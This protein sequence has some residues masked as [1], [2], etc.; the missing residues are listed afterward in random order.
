[1]DNGGETRKHK[2]DGRSQGIIFSRDVEVKYLNQKGK[3]RLLPLTEPLLVFLTESGVLLSLV[4]GLEMEADNFFLMGA[5]AVLALIF[6]LAYKRERLRHLWLGACVAFQALFGLLF[7]YEIK[8]GAVYCI[9]RFIRYVNFYYETNILEYRLDEKVLGSSASYETMF[10]LFIAMIFTFIITFI[11]CGKGGKILY[12]GTTTLFIALPFAV[13]QVPEPVYLMLY[14]GAALAVLGGGFRLQP[15]IRSRVRLFILLCTGILCIFIW[16]IFPQEEYKKKIDADKIKKEIQQVMT[17]VMESKAVSSFLNGNSLFLD[18]RAVGGLSSGSL[19]HVGQ[20]V[21]NNKTALKIGLS[22]KLNRKFYVRGYVG[23]QIN[24][25]QWEAMGR[26]DRDA[27]EELENIWNSDFENLPV[28]WVEM[29]K[30]QGMD[31]KDETK[32][33]AHQQFFGFG[34][35]KNVFDRELI[36]IECIGAGTRDLLLPYYIDNT[37]EMGKKGRLLAEGIPSAKEQ[38]QVKAYFQLEQLLRKLADDDTSSRSQV[39]FSLNM[40]LFSKLSRMLIENQLGVTLEGFKQAHITEG[41]DYPTEEFMEDKKKGIWFRMSGSLDRL[42]SFGSEY[43]SEEID[44]ILEI[45]KFAEK[46]RAYRDFVYE[47]YTRLPEKGAEKMRWDSTLLQELPKKDFKTLGELGQAE[48]A[49]AVKDWNEKG[50]DMVVIEKTASRYMEEL[51]YYVNYIKDWLSAQ[52]DYS[53]SPGTL[54]RGKDFV[55]YFLYEKKKGYCA[56]YATAGVLLFRMAGI[57]ARYV[58]GY[59][60]TSDDYKKAVKLGSRQVLDIKDTNAH[61]WVEVYLNGYGWVPVEMTPG[62]SEIQ[63]AL[64]GAPIEPDLEKD[65]IEKNP[66]SPAAKTPVPLQSPTPTPNVPEQGM[67]SDGNQEAPHPGDV[68]RIK[69]AVGICVIFLGL[70]G[71]LLL[72]RQLIRKKQNRIL[73]GSNYSRRLL[74]C[75]RMMEKLLGSKYGWNTGQRLEEMWE[76]VFLPYLSKEEQ[77]A[78]LEISKKAAFGPGSITKEEWLSCERSY[79]TFKN[80]FLMESSFLMRAYYKYILV[81]L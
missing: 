80:G 59:V 22:K 24:M 31:D 8:I 46:E 18:N 40:I 17:E 30:K 35:H 79:Q 37:I 7:F 51:A 58:E 29:C 70:F 13:G 2:V 81:C 9:N 77:K 45:E 67:E 71:A 50:D 11:I 41:L 20:V 28:E 75:Y 26:K 68:I 44:Q 56:H 36:T 6:W 38:Y 33:L 25:D 52:A 66:A 1:M 76:S 57:P 65:R 55:D 12:T 43:L 74:Y 78:F 16:G 42:F 60:V 32:N 23:S 10:F 62:Y 15:N 63:G 27:Y 54:P 14:L 19:G 64:E 39:N 3:D 5:V 53:L 4:S 49:A 73:Q 72:R 34:F 61:A 69:M 48:M 21:F 47:V